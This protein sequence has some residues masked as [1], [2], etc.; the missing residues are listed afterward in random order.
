MD[1]GEHCSSTNL[2]HLKDFLGF[3]HGGELAVAIQ[4]DEF[5]MSNMFLGVSE[6]SALRLPASCA[7]LIH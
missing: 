3:F 4:R 7:A 5:L 6:K 1:S 2:F